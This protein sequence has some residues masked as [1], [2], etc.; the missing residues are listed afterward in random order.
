MADKTL[1]AAYVSLGYSILLFSHSTPTTS[2]LDKTRIKS[3]IEIDF[4]I[5]IRFLFLILV[6]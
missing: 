5:S 4:S 3:D 6:R 2:I 1:K